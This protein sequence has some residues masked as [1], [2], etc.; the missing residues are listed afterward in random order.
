MSG[1]RPGANDAKTKWSM[2]IAYS[3]LS[4]MKVWFVEQLLTPFTIVV[5]YGIFV[6]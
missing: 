5:N 4:F 3:P 2:H 1:I 6:K